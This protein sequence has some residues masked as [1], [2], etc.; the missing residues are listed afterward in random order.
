MSAAFST[1]GQANSG[2]LL[3]RHTSALVKRE[4]TLCRHYPERSAPSSH[5]STAVSA[6]VLLPKTTANLAM[7]EYA[8]TAPR[9]EASAA[10]GARVARKQLT[11]KS[12]KA[13]S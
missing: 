7:L 10:S 13:R 2:W 9:G 11:D 1:S 12:K 4:V 3:K 8:S 5:R 6:S